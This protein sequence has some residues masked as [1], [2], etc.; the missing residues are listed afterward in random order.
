[1]LEGRIGTG[2]SSRGLKARSL[3]VLAAMVETVIRAGG[4][5]D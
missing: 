3:A 4:V 2:E 1:V 5:P